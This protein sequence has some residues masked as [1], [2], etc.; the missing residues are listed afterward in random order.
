MQILPLNE[1]PQFA[2]QIT[3]WLWQAFGTG[4]T[5]EFYASIVQSSLNG[6]DFPITF[7]ALDAGQAVGTV[8]F[9]RCD[10]ISRQD[11]Y[12]WLAALYIDESARGQGVSQAL[13]QHVIHYAR[14]RG[15]NRLW[16]WSTFAGYYERFGWQFV[17]EALEYPDTRVRVYQRDLHAM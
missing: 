12:P 7:V 2:E 16:L 3:D 11:L 15:Y 17:E 10:L 1:V 14:Q 13:Q 6:A 9:W 4:T 5:R 8:G